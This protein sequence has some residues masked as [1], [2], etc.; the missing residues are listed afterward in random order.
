M[1]AR[2]RRHP[3]AIQSAQDNGASLHARWRPS[4]SF[5]ET[6]LPAARKN[7]VEHSETRVGLMA[8]DIRRTGS[9]H[10]NRR[11]RNLLDSPQRRSL[12]RGQWL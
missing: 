8:D 6:S 4:F 5:R 10:G 2:D 11:R 12:T 3:L 7:L 9:L 1:L